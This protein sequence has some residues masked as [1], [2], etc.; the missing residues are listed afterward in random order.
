MASD[1]VE[2]MQPKRWRQLPPEQRREEFEALLRSP[3]WQFLPDE[4][5]DLIKNLPLKDD[6]DT[7]NRESDLL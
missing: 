4:I 2:K 1:L 3:Y 6:A 7:L 5:Q